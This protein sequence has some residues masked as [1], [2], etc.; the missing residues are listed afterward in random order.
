[1]DDI[2]EIR[3]LK[4]RYF[5]ALDAQDWDLY[6]SV[7]APDV[8]V[9]TTRGGGEKIEGREPFVNYVRQLGIVQSVHQGHMPEIELTGETTATG[10]WALEDYNIYT[11]GSQTHGWG[12]YLETYQK[13]DGRWH[14]KTSSLSYLRFERS[15][16]LPPIIAGAEGTE[17]LSGINPAA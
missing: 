9:D 5:R 16:G 11:D 17:H 12:H 6:A 2:E 8:V 4:A 14:I 13:I 7:F 1:M 10:I 3:K 15:I